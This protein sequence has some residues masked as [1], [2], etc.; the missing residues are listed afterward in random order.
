MSGYSPK[1]IHEDNH[2]LGLNKPPG[3]LVQ[4]DITGD[5]TLLD[6]AKGYLKDKYNKPGKVYCVPVHRIDRPASGAV[7]MAWTSKAL[8]RMNGMIKERQVT[9]KY[10]ALTK[11]P[12]P[13]Q[14]GLLEHYILKDAQK[15]KVQTIPMRKNP[16]KKSKKASLRYELI[17]ELDGDFLLKINLETGRPHQIRAQLS[18]TGCAIIGDLKYGAHEPLEDMSIALH[19]YAMS[20]LH[21][22]QKETTN[23]VAK[24][25][26]TELWNRF[27]SFYE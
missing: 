26:D 14:K 19:S 9:K 1:V 13:K 27:S 21:P 23:V 15:N 6:W 25:P 18:A 20:F 12:P 16:P 4:S 10:Y 11:A 2:L 5:P 24:P 8:S 7:I 3:W 22:V 17:A